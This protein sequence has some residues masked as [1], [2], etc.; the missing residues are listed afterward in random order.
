MKKRLLSLLLCAVLLC[1][2]VLAAGESVDQE[3]TRVTLAVKQAL[4][5]SDDYDKFTNSL[6]DMGALR[7]WSLD[8]SN[9]TDGS[10][11]S[12]L[13]NDNGR[14]MQYRH[15]DGTAS[16]TSEGGYAPA[17]SKVSTA[18]AK[19]AATAFLAAVLAK[20]ESAEL[21]QED[22]MIPLT[23]SNADYS[24]NAQILLNGVQS[25]STAWLQ[26]D[27]DT[28]VVTSFGRSD[29]YE[30][31]VND[32]PSAVPAVS[33][34][35]AA[36]T[37]AGTVSLELQYVKSDKES[38]AVLRYVP[39][40]GDDYYVD[41]QTGKLVDLTDAWNNLKDRDQLTNKGAAASDAAGESAGLSD[42]EQSAIQQMQGVMTKDAL[43]AAARK[44]TALGLSRYTL[45]GASYSADQKTGAVS[46]TLTYYRTLPF[47]ELTGVTSADYQSG[48]YRQYRSLTMNAKTGALLEESSY[49]PWFLKPGSADTGTTS[50]AAADSFL[51]YQYPDYVDQV[52]LHSSD[53]GVYDY[54]RQVNGYFYYGNDVNITVDPSDG[55]VAGF[56][57]TW[58]DG[59]TF[60]SADG[61]LSA[62]QAMKTYC[63]AYSAKL[64]YLAYPVAV[65]TGIPIWATYA[66]NCGSVAYRYVLGY[67]YATDGGTVLGVDAKTGELI[68][69]AQEKGAV[70][71][72]DLGNSYAKT[73]IEALAAAGI[74]FGGGTEFHPTASLTQEDMLVLLLNSYGYSFDT[75]DLDNADALDTLYNAARDQ[76]FLTDTDRNPKQPV[77]KLQFI[78]TIILVSP[79]GPAAQ[80]KGIFKTTFSDAASIPQ[81]DLGCVA[82][83]EALGLVH[84]NASRQLSP[85]AV[86]TRQTAAV[87][88]YNYMN[89]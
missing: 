17:F 73:Q 37:L 35:A 38:K 44:V 10:S 43:D 7:Y 27:P 59:L 81:A 62:Q 68:R 70:S 45:S 32:V 46:C 61:I 29:C 87:I 79:Y 52:A 57:S 4:S 72:T 31:Y 78:R 67:T 82:I 71:Y 49:R 54:V 76:G 33:A 20:D 53:D 12:V 2:P 19:K 6:N 30:A 3:L 8:W 69:M 65:D 1:M 40:T 16:G 5:I 11:I 39:V 21:T 75:A 86:V 84:G 50:R 85:F 80:L 77:T 74:D 64:Q 55:S 24:F 14:V 58:E 25:P 88:L 47:S 15:S 22:R 63:A 51:K 83:A 23:S 26:V 41:A 48:D 9:S 18:A 56:N 60:Q 36:A 42:A 28:G 66:S 89:R 13:A 34:S